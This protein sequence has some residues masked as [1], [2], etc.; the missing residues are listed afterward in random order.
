MV[1]FCRKNDI[2]RNL[3]SRTFELM[4]SLSLNF[5]EIFD[6]GVKKIELNAGIIKKK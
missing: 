1:S 5:H 3:Y 6:G 4:L 2:V